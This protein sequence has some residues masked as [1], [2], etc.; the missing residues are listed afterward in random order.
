MC[1]CFTDARVL[2]TESEDE[3]ELLA[4]APAAKSALVFYKLNARAL[5]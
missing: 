1:Y 5:P 2:L 3:G 4:V